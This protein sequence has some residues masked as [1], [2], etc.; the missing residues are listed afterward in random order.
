MRANTGFRSEWGMSWRQFVAVVRAET[1]YLADEARKPEHVPHV[2]ESDPVSVA[3]AQLR[4]RQDE[5]EY[6]RA[7]HLFNLARVRS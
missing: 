7:R 1:K 6:K 3:A 2:I 5:Q 4:E